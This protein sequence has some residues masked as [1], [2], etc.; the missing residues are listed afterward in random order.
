MTTRERIRR[1]SSRKIHQVADPISEEWTGSGGATSSRNDDVRNRLVAGEILPTFC[2]SLDNV[3]AGCG[4]AGDMA[5]GRG[6]GEWGK[7]RHFGDFSVIP[8]DSRKK[9]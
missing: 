8:C 9:S 1:S 4:W 6:R 5:D 3:A 2:V 7:S